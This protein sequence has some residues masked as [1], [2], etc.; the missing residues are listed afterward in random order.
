MPENKAWCN[1]VLITSPVYIALCLSP[2]EFRAT[3][4]GMGIPSTKWP[5]PQGTPHS[6]AT[7][8]F[9]ERKGKISAVVYLGSAK[10]REAEEVC[11][12]LVHEAVHIWQEIRANLGEKFPSSEFEAYS[13]QAI[14][15]ALF[16]KFAELGGTFGART[17]R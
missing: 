15:Q 1:R 10:G 3:L 9:F 14:S 17:Q 5:D 4:K 8:H 11:G 7:T 16:E 6:H 13:I 2:K 12:L